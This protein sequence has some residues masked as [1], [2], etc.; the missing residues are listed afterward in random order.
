MVHGAATIAASAGL[1]FAASKFGGGSK[2]IPSNATQ[3][4][5]AGLLAYLAIIAVTGR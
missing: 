2:W 5:V 1:P 4:A 3:A